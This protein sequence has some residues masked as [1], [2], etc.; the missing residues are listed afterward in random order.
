MLNIV[1]CN[2]ETVLILLFFWIW[3]LWE[4]LTYKQFVRDFKTSTKWKF[5]K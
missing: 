2:V 1:E 4:Y 5:D 3:N